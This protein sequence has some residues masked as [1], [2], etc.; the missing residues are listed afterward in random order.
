MKSYI[1]Y[2]T[3]KYKREKNFHYKEFNGTFQ[4]SKGYESGPRSTLNPWNKIKMAT[5]V[6]IVQLMLVLTISNLHAYLRISKAQNYSKSNF[7]RN[8]WTNH[9]ASYRIEQFLNIRI[10]IKICGSTED[11]TSLGILRFSHVNY[12]NEGR[13]TLRMP[14]ARNGRAE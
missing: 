11:R 7:S 8:I 5:V 1:T 3:T 10:C 2:G 14:V 9:F 4:C 12:C 13:T 6:S